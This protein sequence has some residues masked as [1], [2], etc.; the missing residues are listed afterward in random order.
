MLI[1]VIVTTYN[2]PKALDRVLS[3][4]SEQEDRDFEV[5]VGDDGSREETGLL[6]RQWAGKF[7]VA[8]KHAWQEDR[9]FR[10]ARV[11]NLAASEASGEYFLF[12][13]GDCVPQRHWVSR[14]R[15]LAEPG[16]MVAG[17]RVLLSERFTARVED[18]KISLPDLGAME[19]GRLVMRKDLNRLLPLVSIPTSLFRKIGAGRWQK[20]RTCNLGVWREDFERING[21]DQVFSGWGYE[22]TDL[23]V[24]LL[25]SGVRHKSG[26]FATCVFH[27]YHPENDRSNRDANF[28]RVMDRLKSGVT[29]AEI[30]FRELKK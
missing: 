25:N 29:Q 20:V 12:L 26:A 19:I 1:S 13:D 24:R 2:R 5:I 9:G 8:L 4:L 16:W 21:F 14:H 18:E 6:V 11:R 10:A 30:G 22:D 23:A 27:L 7:P 15:G 28:I 3:A 17:N